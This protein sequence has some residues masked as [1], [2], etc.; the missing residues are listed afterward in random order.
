MI[1]IHCLFYPGTF[2]QPRI[3]WFKKLCEQID[4]EPEVNFYPVYNSESIIRGRLKGYSLGTSPYVGFVDADDLIEPGIFKKILNE[5]EKGAE[6]VTCLENLI[7]GQGRV[8]MP[9]LMQ[10]PENYPEFARKIFRYKDVNHH[11]FCFKRELLNP[12][13]KNDSDMALK[14]LHLTGDDEVFS[15]VKNLADRKCVL[16]QEVGYYYRLHENQSSDKW[17]RN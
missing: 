15:A 14:E 10:S 11:I 2:T 17:I 8:V 5:F 12:N 7:D 6:V 9:G 16:I 13:Y 3:D 1:D 4:K